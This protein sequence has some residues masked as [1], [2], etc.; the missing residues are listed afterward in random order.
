MSNAAESIQ[1]QTDSLEIPAFLDKRNKEN[2][3]THAEHS[4]PK[5]TPDA[6]NI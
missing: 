1:D 3:V 5:D 6:D 4:V 2:N